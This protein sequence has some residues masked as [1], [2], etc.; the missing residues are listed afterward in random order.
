MI[1]GLPIDQQRTAR[2]EQLNPTAAPQLPPEQPRRDEDD[3]DWDPNDDT[4]SAPLTQQ[5]KQPAE[6]DMYAEALES[7]DGR[8]DY[9]D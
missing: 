4:P 3:E 2:K 6:P 8:S 7:D 5:P 9:S 1:S